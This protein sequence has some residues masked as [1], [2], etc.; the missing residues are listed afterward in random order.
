[1]SK[2]IASSIKRMTDEDGRV[3]VLLTAEGWNRTPAEQTVIENKEFE[4]IVVEI[5]KKSS[6]RSLDQNAM[7]WSLLTQIAL[8]TSGTKSKTAVEQ[9]Y[10]A[11][12][13][14]AQAH[15]E[16]I[17]AP[18]NTEEGLRKAFRVIREMGMREVNGKTLTMYQCFIGSSKYDT[19]EMTVL[20]D[21]A[22]NKCDELGID[23]SEVR[24]IA[25][26]HK[27]H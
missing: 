25:Q 22:L 4:Q 11:I 18:K 16:Y 7:L 1:M 24:T 12:L 15:Y 3:V 19:A 8:A 14:E 13:E 10:C 17:L 2:F 20:I 23:N 6:Q 5:K 26:E 9:I 21:T 27:N